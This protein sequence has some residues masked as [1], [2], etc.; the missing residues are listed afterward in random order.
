M[1]NEISCSWPEPTREK[2]HF[3]R[4]AER[5]V[6]FFEEVQAR[7]FMYIGPGS[8][9]TWIYLQSIGTTSEENSCD[10]S[11]K[12]TVFYTV[13]KRVL[14]CEEVQTAKMVELQ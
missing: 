2:E 12:I 8:E 13:D 9:E 5:N 4:D 1:M 14:L 11:I 6:A 7:H 3:L 10:M